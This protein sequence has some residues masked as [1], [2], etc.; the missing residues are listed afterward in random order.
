MNRR[1]LSLIAVLAAALTVSGKEAARAAGFTLASP[2]RTAVVLVPAGEPECVRLAAAD[3]VGDVRKITGRT[4]TTV[5]GGTGDVV[6]VSMD[7]PGSAALLET[8]APGFGEGLRGKWEAYRVEVVGAR[9]IVAGSDERGTMFGL[10]DFI[11]HYLGVDPLWYWASRPPP[12]RTTL[13]WDGVRLASGGP[14]FRFRGWFLNDEDLLTEWKEGGGRRRIEYPYYGQVVNREV[15]RAVAGALVRSRCNLIIPASFVDILN[16]PEEALVQECARRGVFVSQH[17]VEPMGVSAFSYFNYWKQRGKDLKYSYFSHPEE[18]REV[19]RA[20]AEKWAGYSNVIWQLGLRGIGDRPMWMADANTP[21][22]DAERGR[23]ISDAMAAQMKILDEVCPGRPHRASTTLW[24]EGAVLNGKGLLAIPEGTIVVFADNSPGWKWQPDFYSTPRNPKNT[25][26]V[27]YHHGLI[28]SGPH[29]AQVVPPRKTF[30]CLQ[31]AVGKGAGTYA[32]F[33]VSNLREF[34]LGIDATAKMTWRMDS[35]DP[36]AW[37]ADWVRARFS[38]Q[39]DEIVNAYRVYFAAW[40]IHDEQQVPF[41]MD[42]QMF[43]AGHAALGAIGKRLKEKGTEGGRPGKSAPVAR[44]PAPADGDAFHAGLSD[45]H[46][47]SLGREETAR[48][49]AVQ[50]AGLTLARDQARKAAAA[51]PESE[52]AFLNDNLV[53]PAAI[54]VQTC[55]WLEQVGVAQEALD[56]GSR[57][58]CAAALARA[59]A[60]FAQIPILAEGY[61]RGPWEHWYRGCKKLNIAATLQRTREVLGQSRQVAT[62]R[63]DVP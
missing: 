50:K 40:Q 43:G 54:M 25:Y 17:H 14:A 44:K 16:P 63:G 62:D 59:E 2:D 34:V 21:Q 20:Y 12:R 31:T 51:L 1:M 8:L 32:I 6:V 38:R 42:G 7:R 57:A 46:P 56:R 26:G 53:Y 55:A 29:L 9:L 28:G 52:A 45:T 60:A 24:A 4:L 30:E 22:S 47:R 49:L 37:M 11:E 36:D 3:L 41:L 15:M 35:F 27:Y 61:C 18:V 13:A 33:N 5:D 48:R 23:L 58:D 39:Q 19:W 10:Y